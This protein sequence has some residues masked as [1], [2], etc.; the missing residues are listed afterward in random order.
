MSGFIEV[1]SKWYYVLHPRPV[2]VLVAERNGKVN[3]MAAS[4]VMPF[5]EEPPRVVAALDKEALTTAYIKSSRCFTI[6]VLDI[7]YKDFVYTAGTVSGRDVDKVSLLKASTT[8]DTATGAPRL[9]QPEPIGYLDVRVYRILEDLAEDVDLVVGDVV[10]SY[11]RKDL[12]SRYGWDL[13]KTKI[14]L[15]SAGRAF[16]TQT[17]IFIAKK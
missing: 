7:G 13:K 6:N 8:R 15:H 10:S 14:L 1:G 3:F 12:F 17:G 5:S 2:Y 11:A 16:T 9:T 4:W